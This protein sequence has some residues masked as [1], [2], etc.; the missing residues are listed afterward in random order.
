MLKQILKFGLIA[1]LI[2]GIP[3]SILC[4]TLK[5]E[6]PADWAWSSAT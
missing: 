1:G 3:L 4:L 6:P 5:D 2:V